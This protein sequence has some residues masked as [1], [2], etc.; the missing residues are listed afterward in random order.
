MFKVVI[1]ILLLSWCGIAYS[2]SPMI[3]TGR[4]HSL[5][6]DAAGDV[7]AWGCDDRGQLGV[8]RETFFASPRQIQLPGKVVLI[9]AGPDFT[10]ALQD[11]GSVWSWGKNDNGQL[12][13]GTRSASSI[14]AKIGSGFTAIS[15]GAFHTLGLKSDGSLWGWGLNGWG[16]LSDKFDSAILVPQKIGSGYVAVAAGGFHS[17]A[18]KADGTLWSWGWN[19]FGQLGDGSSDSN[20]LIPKQVGTAKY[21]FVSAGAQHSLALR[22]DGT[23]WAWGMN[24]DGQLGIG[25][26]NTETCTGWGVEMLCSKNPFL[27][28]DKYIAIAGGL[29]QTIGIKADGTLWAWGRTNLVKNWV[30]V[31]IGA[32]F[33]VVAPGGDLAITKDGRLWKVGTDGVIE[34]I[35]R[36]STII[37]MAGSS[38]LHAIGIK[39][40]GTI[41]GWGSNA[42]GQLGDGSATFSVIPKYIGSGFQLVAAGGDYSFGLKSDNSLWAWGQ[43]F[44]ASPTKVGSDYMTVSAA[45]NHYLALGT[46]GSLWAGGSNNQG[47]FG[48]GT[49]LAKSNLQRIGGQFSAI[50]VGYDFSLG[51]K[52]DGS[53]WAWGINDHGQTGASST[54]QCTQFTNSPLVPCNLSPIQ[55]GSGI[56]SIAAGF[57]HSLAISSTGDLLAWGRNSS[58]QIGDGTTADVVSPKKIGIGF[59]SIFAGALNS[60]GIKTDGSVFAW[61]NNYYGNFGDGTNSDRPNP[62]RVDALNNVWSIAASLERTLALRIDGRVMTFG[63]NDQGQLGDGT[64][65]SHRSP[66]LVVNSTVNGFLNL[67][68]GV[69]TKTPTSLDVPFYLTSSGGISDTSALVTSTTKFNPADSGKVGS[70]FVTAS[71]P[72]SS[73]GAL[74][75]TQNIPNAASP[76]V[77]RPAMLAGT[78]S[79]GFTLIQLTPTGWQTVVNGKLVP[80]ASGVLGDQLSAQTILNGTDTTNLK[81]AE[82]CVGYGTNAQDMIDNGNIRAIATIPGAATPST[83]AVGTTLSSSISVTPGWN[84]LGNP[85]NQTILVSEK[86]GDAT[87]ISSVWKWDAVKGNWQFY[88]PA[89]SAADLSTYATSQN[90]A[91]LSEISPG[92]GYWV[93]AKV[94]AD[95][96]TVSGSAVYLRQSSLASGWNLVSTA[97]PISAKD[98]NLTLSTTP[99]TSGQV[100]INMTSL[101]AWD[102]ARSNWY[103]YAPS[104]EAQGGTALVDYISSKGYED[105]TT[106]GKTLGNGAGIWVNRP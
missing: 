70:V 36:S 100:P 33:A 66:V 47:Q 71:V 91:L 106:S 96:G 64:F 77:V 12:G 37:T 73:L 104:L 60:F 69:A 105:F 83:C 45:W 41:F 8:G 84:L 6:L 86:F 76:K 35:L 50:A 23:L 39:S 18:I 68:A 90:Y 32:G 53:L 89:M 79:T 10:V 59:K 9:S 61:G 22:D 5:A 92:D 49:T 102:S 48:D 46:D 25:D 62:T 16:Q 88:A 43:G 99:P 15:S 94:Q 54:K 78:A 31:Q 34:E 26:T 75:V 65:A 85:I 29:T 80:Y 17:L 14:P 101:W 24:S 13:N 67:D 19:Y 81:G 74:A 44:S 20:R 98:F 72:S 30:P 27:V 2:V 1:R 40:D 51:L 93:N 97:S 103:F 58:G 28:G 7:S 21:K 4:C 11:D 63:Q 3:A 42:N 95:L 38:Q 87:K 52:S 57:Y 56:A 55:I 82:F